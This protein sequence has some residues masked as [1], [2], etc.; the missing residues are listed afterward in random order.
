MEQKS[1]VVLDSLGYAVKFEHQAQLIDWFPEGHEKRIAIALMACTGMRVLELDRV[2]PSSFWW[3]R[4][5]QKMHLIWLTVK[6]KPQQRNEILPDWLLHEL[7]IFFKRYFKGH[8][9]DDRLFNFKAESLPSWLNK[10]AKPHLGGIFD[11]LRPRFKGGSIIDEHV[12]QLKG[13]RH[14]FAATV[15][16]NLSR[17]YGC[18]MAIHMVSKR[19]RHS[20][21]MVTARHYAS[22]VQYLKDELDLWPGKEPGQIL[23]ELLGYSENYKLDFASIKHQDIRPFCFDL[24]QLMG[25]SACT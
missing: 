6:S 11:A 10:F 4:K 7:D 20:S 12:V 8:G 5:N 21:T 16:W 19:M 9:W 13:L 24:G 15:F 3:D 2:K 17:I 18:E 1:F 25:D 23:G 14:A 22:D